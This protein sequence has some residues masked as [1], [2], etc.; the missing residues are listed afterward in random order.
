MPIFPAG[1]LFKRSPHKDIYD[2]GD[3]LLIVANDAILNPDTLK[4]EIIEGKGEAATELS[5]FWFRQ[6]A[7]L[8][9]NHHVAADVDA[10]LAANTSNTDHFAKR[11][12]LVTKMIPLPVKCWV[13][14]YLTGTV[15]EEYRQT[16]AVAGIQLPKGMSETERFPAPVFIP[17]FKKSSCAGDFNDLKEFC[18]QH[19]SKKIRNLALD[20]YFKAWKIAQR[21]NILLVSCVFRFGLHEDKIHLIGECITPDSCLFAAPGG[22]K[23]GFTLTKA[24]ANLLFPAL[25]GANQTGQEC[26]RREKK[27]TAENLKILFSMLTQGGQLS[28]GI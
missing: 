28:K 10:F 9:P 23:N 26:S 4:I 12:T 20:L 17:L 8:C 16:G 13:Q 21:Q 2:F 11:S 14:G 19:L 1:V 5:A 6:L 18:G 15:W 27:T 25:T 24:G 7:D 22:G 3:K